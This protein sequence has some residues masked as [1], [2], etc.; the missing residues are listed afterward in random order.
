VTFLTEDVRD[1]AAYAAG[2]E[3]ALAAQRL[4]RS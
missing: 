1:G 2:L 4:G 3:A